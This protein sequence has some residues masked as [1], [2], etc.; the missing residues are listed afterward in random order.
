MAEEKPFRYGLIVLGFFLVMIGMF[1][2]SVER[3]Q[4]YIT[5]CTLGIL[6]IVVGVIWSM[7]QCYPKI[8][9]VSID[10]ESE[11][12]LIKK[13]GALSLESTIP[14]KN[15]SQTPYTSQ[16]QADVYEKSL[17]SYEQVQK[18][19]AGIPAE[20][21]G[22]LPVAPVPLVREGEHIQQVVEA[23]A[24]VHRNSE[25]DGDACND[26]GSQKTATRPYH[27]SVKFHSQAPLASLQDEMDASS[28][29]S[30]PNS[31]LL[32]KWKVTASTVSPSKSQLRFKLPCYEDF[33]L[34]D[35]VMLEDQ[36]QTMPQNQSHGSLPA[37][38]GEAPG[39]SEQHRVLEHKAV[40]NVKE[41]DM[42][43]G[44]QDGPGDDI[45]ST[46]AAFK[47]KD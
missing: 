29:E 19:M 26:P 1:I 33:A 9:V 3:P 20:C 41:D 22:A 16:K 37:L 36:N 2:M 18:N 45:P 17:P 21:L 13:P 28:T 42:Y 10:A 40:Q 25:S 39:A 6:T 27:R 35:S 23:K 15:S 14:E 11:R 8:R 44:I 12:F 47:P 34:I 24:E 30:T 38:T 7:C 32:Q 46:E 4:I 43:Y 31:P 5:F